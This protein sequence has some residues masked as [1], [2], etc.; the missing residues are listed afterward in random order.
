MSGQSFPSRLR[1]DDLAGGS[2][3]GAFGASGRDSK[4]RSGHQTGGAPLLADVEQSRLVLAKTLDRK[5]KAQHG[6]FF[7]PAETARFM[8]GLFSQRAGGV[9]RLLDAGAGIGSLSVAFLERW[10]AGRRDFQRV[11]V[12]AFEIDRGLHPWLGRSLKA[13]TWPDNVVPTIRGDDF[14]HVAVDSLCGTLFAETLPRYTHAILNPP[15][16]KIRGNS[17]HRLALRR[18]GIETVNLYSA[19][20]ALAI[21]LLEDRG[22]LVAIIPRS[23]CNGLYYRPFR[24]Y[25][26]ERAAILRLHLFA[27]RNRAF[28]DDA[29]LQE[30]IIIVL[31]RGMRQGAVTV[32]TSTDSSFTDLETHRYA[33]DRIVL[34][35]DS[36]HVIHV[37]TS[38][39]VSAIEGSDVV[40]CTLDDIG[41]EVS[42]GPVVAFRL[43]EHLRGMP[44]TGTAPLLHPCHFKDQTTDWPKAASSKPNAIC[45]NTDTEKWLYPNGFYCVVRRL[46][47]K[48]EKRRIVASVVRP[49]SFPRVEALGFENHLNVFHEGKHGLPEA[50]AYGL[51]T[52]L[53][54][55]AVD[56]N[57]RR[58]NGHTQVNAGDLRRIRYPNKEELLALGKR[59]MRTSTG[60]AFFRAV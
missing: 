46:S 42:T 59:V 39:R 36:E 31:E 5:R 20:V 51:A 37:P 12:D 60:R 44:A 50:L 25:V 18:V 6:Q 16:K 9:C 45:S 21:S 54:T 19:F 28:K 17:M 7:T 34:R 43:K 53:N 57:F 32:T 24:E 22:Q 3:E 4:E 33:F 2:C 23:F 26:L 29:V 40:C 10:V 30:N 35:G 38:P 1:G 14:V 27:S 55:A 47:S 49:D 13:C 41:I 52:F 8:A 58:F 11:E 15:Y 56:E 48:E